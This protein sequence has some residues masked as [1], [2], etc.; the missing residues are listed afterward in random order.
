MSRWPGYLWAAPNTLLGLAVGLVGI[1]GGGR[2]RLVDGVLEIHGRVLR[3]LLALAIPIV[4][5]AA[6]LTLGHV[7]LGRDPDCLT[8]CRSHERVHVRQYERWGPLFLPAYFLSSLWALVRGRD[9]YRDNAFEREAYRLE[10]SE[11]TR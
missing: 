10:A 7:V 3:R 1:V 8:R 9:P 11:E 2:I 5:G 6:A 4:G